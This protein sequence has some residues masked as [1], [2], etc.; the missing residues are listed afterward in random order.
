[1]SRI[2]KRIKENEDL[3]FGNMICCDRITVSEHSLLVRELNTFK[4]IE[5]KGF[6]KNLKTWISVKNSN[7][8]PTRCLG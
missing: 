3:L 1:M 2:G 4:P 5:T 8:K 7:C 6:S